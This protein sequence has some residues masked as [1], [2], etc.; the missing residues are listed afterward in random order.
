M[1][2]ETPFL[3]DRDLESFL[4]LKTKPS[5]E[6]LFQK[7]LSDPVS[8]VMKASSK[9]LRKAL[10]QLGVDIS[11]QFMT[12]PL[13]PETLNKALAVI[14]FLHTGSIVVDDVEDESRE[15]RGIPCVHRTHGVPIAINAG[16]WLYFK[17]TRMIE[18]IEVSVEAKHLLLK[19]CNDTLLRA[20]YGQALDIGVALTSIPQDQVP[21]VATA[22]IQLKSGELCSLAFRM[23]FLLHNLPGSMI[24]AADNFGKQ[25]GI[26]L[27]MFDDIGNIQSRNRGS[28]WFEDLRLK[29]ITSLMSSAAERLTPNA[30][31]QLMRSIDSP[32]QN[33]DSIL[34]QLVDRGV[35][36]Y[37]QA[38]ANAVLTTAIQELDAKITMEPQHLSALKNL[39]ERLRRAYE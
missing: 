19:E 39:S 1:N 17:S 14:D 12:A 5:L 34:D 13:P 15:R 30:Y 35:I 20:H 28:K 4:R 25:F 38:R 29:R 33:T 22:I 36:N 8:E 6:G 16:T 10:V 31:R 26:A 7:T 37:A 11:D 9:N 32:Q 24:S 3:I 21:E 2:T 23:G 27:Q 18:S